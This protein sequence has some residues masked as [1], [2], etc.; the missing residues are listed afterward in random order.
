MIVSI[1]IPSQSIFGKVQEVCREGAEGLNL[2]KNI[3]GLFTPPHPVF[4]LQN[5]VIAI[6]CF[7][8]HCV[9]DKTHLILKVLNHL[10]TD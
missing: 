8:F 10:I 9:Q 4:S 6:V 5:D 2:K 7:S 1:I 3:R